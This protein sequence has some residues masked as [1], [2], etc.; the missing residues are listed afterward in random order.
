[1]LYKTLWVERGVSRGPQAAAATFYFIFF[2]FVSFL[3]E[4]LFVLIREF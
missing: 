1:M 4:Q 3:C 2:L